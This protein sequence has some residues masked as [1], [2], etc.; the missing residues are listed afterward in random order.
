MTYH[1]DGVSW[2]FKGNGN[3]VSVVTAIGWA[4]L[5]N[6]SSACDNCPTVVPERTWTVVG[7]HPL[8]QTET[9]KLS[10]GKSITSCDFVGGR[11]CIPVIRWCVT[12]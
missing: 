12:V 11:V 3:P 8:L 7:L 5:E 9:E 1:V 4:K 10:I 2:L 6:P